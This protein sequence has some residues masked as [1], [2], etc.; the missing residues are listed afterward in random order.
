MLVLS[1]KAGEAIVIGDRI[2]VRVQRVSRNRV[3]LV[4][5]AP[6]NV[7]VDR[8]EIWLQKHRDHECATKQLPK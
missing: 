1:R 3:R 6:E 5:E 7:S 8:K 2:E 4:V